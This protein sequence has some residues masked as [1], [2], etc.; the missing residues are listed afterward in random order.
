MKEKTQKFRIQAYVVTLITGPSLYWELK[1]PYDGIYHFD[2]RT[3]KYNFAKIC[4]FSPHDGD[5]L[6]CHEDVWSKKK[7]DDGSL[8]ERRLRYYHLWRYDVQKLKFVECPCGRVHAYVF[9]PLGFV[10]MPD[11][12]KAEW[13]FYDAKDFDEP[14][15]IGG[16]RLGEKFFVAKADGG[17][18]S[19]CFWQNKKLVREQWVS[20]DWCYFMRHRGRF[21]VGKRLD[22]FYEIFTESGRVFKPRR[23]CFLKEDSGPFGKIQIFAWDVQAKAFILLYHGYDIMKGEAGSVRTPWLNTYGFV[24]RQKKYELHAFDA[25]NY[26]PYLFPRLD[27]LRP[28]PNQEILL[29]PSVD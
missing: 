11:R 25:E 26:Q 7:R 19:V 6:V 24:N 29:M 2:N 9:C 1:L 4:Y 10:V 18:L 28:Y 27:R 8:Y 5:L 15:F 23:A 21:L 22:G 20:S 17:L 3:G 13:L 16:G 12:N 14:Q